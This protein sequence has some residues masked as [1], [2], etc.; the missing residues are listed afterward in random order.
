[1]AKW[2][3]V[4]YP[5]EENYSMGRKEKTIEAKDH[6]EAMRIAWNEFPE[7]H[8]IGA[9]EENNAVSLVDGHIDE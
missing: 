4:A 9:Y 8:I 7:Y 5:D 3:I 1:M 2:K 6:D